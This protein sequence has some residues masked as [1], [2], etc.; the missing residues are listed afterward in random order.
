MKKSELKYTSYGNKKKFL[1]KPTRLEIIIAIIILAIVVVAFFILKNPIEE[2]LA[3]PIN[4]PPGNA[5]NCSATKGGEVCEPEFEEP[6]GPVYDY[7]G[8]DPIGSD[9]TISN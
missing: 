2:E 7:D 1:Q 6:V 4:N 3:K 9:S 8:L 5:M